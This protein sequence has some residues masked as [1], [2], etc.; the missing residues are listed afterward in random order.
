VTVRAG[1]SRLIVEVQTP[2]FCEKVGIAEDDRTPGERLDDCD[3][4]LNRIW[5]M[6]ESDDISGEVVG[7]RITARQER[8]F[9]L[10]EQ[11]TRLS[12]MLERL[13]ER[14]ENRRLHMES[15]AVHET[16]RKRYRTVVDFSV[17]RRDDRSQG[18]LIS[19]NLSM[20]EAMSE[21]FEETEPVTDQDALELENK[22][23]LLNLMLESPEE[24][25]E[26]YLWYRGF[27]G[28]ELTTTAVV[29]LPLLSAWDEEMGVEVERV[30]EDI[31][32]NDIV[33]RVRGN[34]VR[35]L[36]QYEVGTHLV[37]PKHGLPAAIR[38][39]AVTQWPAKLEDEYRFGPIVRLYPEGKP[40][41]DVRT[42]M[43]G[44]PPVT[45][46]QFRA[47]TLSALPR[48]GNS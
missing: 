47:F 35:Q 23:A 4:A 26:V 8:R 34:H 40:V 21:L 39:D 14:L 44:D 36:V 22:L 19:S 3:D 17:I 9:A 10:K 31:P 42:G 43:V 29:A 41:L 15:S 48:R 16:N 24:Q 20:Y 7:G 13:D 46:D 6:L 25:S 2:N 28:F 37:L 1:E 33:F 18:N 27:T 38:V 5:D 45:P 30:K 32:P 11:A 12:K